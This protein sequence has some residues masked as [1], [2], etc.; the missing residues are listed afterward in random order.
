[1]TLGVLVALIGASAGGWLVGRLTLKP[2]SRM[3]EQ[4][5]QIH[6]LNLRDRW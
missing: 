2:L 6:E 3:A 1:M 5:R 4:T